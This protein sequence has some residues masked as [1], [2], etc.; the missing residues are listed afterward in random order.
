[1]SSPQKT[2][3]TPTCPICIGY[4]LLHPE[5]TTYMHM[6]DIWRKCVTCGYCIKDVA[7]KALEPISEQQEEYWIVQNPLKS[8][9]GK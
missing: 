3:S 6:A 2:N 1:M 5:T 4:L 9:T 8:S 7:L